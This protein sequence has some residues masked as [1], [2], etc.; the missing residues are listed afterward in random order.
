MR[1][2]KI[3]D[4]YSSFGYDAAVFWMTGRKTV[5]SIYEDVFGIIHEFASGMKAKEALNKMT[6]GDMYPKDNNEFLKLRDLKD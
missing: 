5:G 6:A 3:V 2:K 4:D 1:E